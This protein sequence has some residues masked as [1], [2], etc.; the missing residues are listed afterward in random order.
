MPRFSS[1]KAR[2]LHKTL[3]PVFQY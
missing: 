3:I 1:S 2:H